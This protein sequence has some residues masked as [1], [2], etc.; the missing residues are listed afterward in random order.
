M[1]GLSYPWLQIWLCNPIPQLEQLDNIE[2]LQF[3]CGTATC[4]SYQSP[5]RKIPKA[6]KGIEVENETWRKGYEFE[7]QWISDIL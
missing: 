1:T 4:Y 3:H 6:I 2:H 7:I 5:I